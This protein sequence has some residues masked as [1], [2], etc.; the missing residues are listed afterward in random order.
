[1]RVESSTRSQTRE[2]RIGEG[3]YRHRATAAGIESVTTNAIIEIAA[4]TVKSKYTDR[5]AFVKPWAEVTGE[6]LLPV[7]TTC[8]PTRRQRT[9]ESACLRHNSAGPALSMAN[10]VK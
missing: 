10:L 1:M 4:N 6:N 2:H 3:A 8:V 5:L 9:Q 7:H